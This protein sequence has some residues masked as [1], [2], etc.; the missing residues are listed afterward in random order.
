MSF[1]IRPSIPYISLVAIADSHFPSI[2][3]GPN[4]YALVI[5]GLDCVQCTLMLL[6]H[7]SS[8][9]GRCIQCVLSFT[10][11]STYIWM[12]LDVTNDFVT[13]FTNSPV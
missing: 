13:G 12:L 11:M 4:W 5:I 3:L 7:H 10:G 8:W 9:D 2:Q 6:F 1:S